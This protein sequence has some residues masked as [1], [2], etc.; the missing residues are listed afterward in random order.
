MIRAAPLINRRLVGTTSAAQ[1]AGWPIPQQP[2]R[3][4]LAFARVRQLGSAVAAARAPPARANAVSDSPT[5]HEVVSATKWLDVLAAARVAIEDAVADVQQDYCLPVGRGV[6]AS[7]AL[8]A[9]AVKVGIALRKARNSLCQKPHAGEAAGA[10]SPPSFATHLIVVASMC[11]QLARVVQLSAVLSPNRTHVLLAT[12]GWRLLDDIESWA[13]CSPSAL[14]SAQPSGLLALRCL[15]LAGLTRAWGT[16][17]AA[18]RL[19]GDLTHAQHDHEASQRVLGKLREQLT[20]APAATDGGTGAHPSLSHLLDRRALWASHLLRDSACVAPLIFPLRSM[21]EALQHAP[22]NASATA[23]HDGASLTGAGEAWAGS[24]GAAAPPPAAG[25][26]ASDTQDVLAE[27]EDLLVVE[28]ASDADEEA[29][30]CAWEADPP[31]ATPRGVA[32]FAADPRSHFNEAPPELLTLLSRVLPGRYLTGSKST[33]AA[34]RPSFAPAGTMRW[35]FDLPACHAALPLHMEGAGGAAG[36]AAPD[37]SEPATRLAS[38]D[39]PGTGKGSSAAAVPAAAAPGDSPRVR[40]VRSVPAAAAWRLYLQYVEGLVSEGVSRPPY[41]LRPLPNFALGMLSALYLH[42]SAEVVKLEARASR[43]RGPPTR[44][45]L[46]GE[47]GVTSPRHAGSITGPA[48]SPSLRRAHPALRFME[49][50]WQ[51]DPAALPFILDAALLPFR[52]RRHGSV[53]SRLPDNELLLRLLL[54]LSARATSRRPGEEPQQWYELPSYVAARRRGGE[55]RPDDGGVGGLG[56]VS[57]DR[58][59]YAFRFVRRAHLEGST[60]LSR[61][62]SGR[63][64][65]DPA[66]LQRMADDAGAC[67][68]ADGVAL[69]LLPSLAACEALEADAGH[70]DVWGQADLRTGRGAQPP[71][72]ADGHA[73]VIS[74]WRSPRCRTLT[75]ELCQRY[76]AGA[77]QPGRRWGFDAV[78][79]AGALSIDDA[80]A[81]GDEGR[82]MEGRSSSRRRSGE[83]TAVREQV[84]LLLRDLGLD[85]PPWLRLPQSQLLALAYIN[86]RCDDVVRSVRVLSEASAILAADVSAAAEAAAAAGPR[87]ASR[88]AVLAYGQAAEAALACAA[89]VMEQRTHEAV[90]LLEDAAVLHLLPPLLAARLKVRLLAAVVAAGPSVERRAGA[91]RGRGAAGSSSVERAQVRQ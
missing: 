75:Q 58:P 5:R 63:R 69:R 52:L 26:L 7:S 82:G 37:R 48:R 73:P 27:G 65:L 33:G 44:Q 18:S 38:S 30:A 25:A 53:V 2:A 62:R 3:I 23:A 55:Q 41:L 45:A 66:R 8:E 88:S 1:R 6:A 29:G 43:E 15:L 67:R 74:P 10:T 51:A 76:D 9:C 32:P 12:V 50:S 47:A 70:L 57:A 21:A 28:D 16:K 72:P 77:R 13:H 36:A 20:T 68:A 90:R 54:Q 91:A 87:Q 14:A 24:Q 59:R 83:G 64:P 79:G 80:W 35:P 78:P 49:G 71:Q 17:I 56:E 42:A 39:A 81:E 61:A 22:L 40:C 86:W 4:L 84:T 19:R 89:S 11:E 31:A 60:H 85:L 46:E 34:P